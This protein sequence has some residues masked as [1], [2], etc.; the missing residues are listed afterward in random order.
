MI[1]WPMPSVTYYVALPFVRTA[2]GELMTGEA[3]ECASAGVAIAAARGMALRSDAAGAVAFS[4]TGDP[5][6]GE[7]SDA[8]LI[9]KFGEVAEDLSGL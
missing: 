6:L 2:D 8:E 3:R 1:N 4:R 9:E 5:A 7:F